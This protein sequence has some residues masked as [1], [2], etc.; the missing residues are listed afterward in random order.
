MSE[1][2]SRG[3]DATRQADSQAGLTPRSGRGRRAAAGAA[4]VM[5]AVGGAAAWRAGVFG[6][7]GSPVTAAEGAAPPATQAVTRQDLSATTPLNATLGYAGSYAVTGRGSGTLTWL[8]SA[9]QV[10]SQGQALYRVD[11]GSPVV[12]LFGSVPDWRPMSAGD[13]G[14]DVSQLNHDLVRLGYADSA[15]IGALGWDYY[16]WE[17]S[18]GVQRMEEHLGVASPPGSLT[19]GSVVFEPGALRVSQVTGSLGGQAGGPVL[20]GT[21]TRHVVTISLDASQQAEVKAGDEV[22]VTLP[23]GM[24]T[25]GTV[26]WVGRV[27]TASSGGSGG[28]SGSDGGGNGGSDAAATIPVTVTLT[29]TAVAG[30]LDQAPVTVNLTTGSVKNALAV[31]VGALLAQASGGYAVEVAGADSTRHLVPVQVGPVFDDADGLV[32]V[33]GALTPGQLVVVP[34]A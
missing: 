17:T 7:G 1:T 27:A 25:P 9:G 32:Q 2:F 30:S 16:S 19:L 3:R 24:T 12:L 28:N 22:T 6:H 33:A 29:H 26:S 8:P 21:S 11:N 13:T 34:A 10:I 15:D 18:L 20:D 14:A 23:D 5:V 4:A 31:P